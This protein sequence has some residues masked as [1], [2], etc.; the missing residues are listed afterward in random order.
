MDKVGNPS[1]SVCGDPVSWELS[2][3]LE[4][5]KIEPERVRL[6]NLH[7]WSRCQRTADEDER[8]IAGAMVMIALKLLVL[9]SC[10]YM[11][12]IHSPIHALAV[13]TSLNRESIYIGLYDCT[14]RVRISWE[15]LAGTASHFICCIQAIFFIHSKL[16]KIKSRTFVRISATLRFFCSWKLGGN[17][18]HFAIQRHILIQ[19]RLD[20]IASCDALQFRKV[21][22]KRK[23]IWE[24]SKND[25]IQ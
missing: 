3:A 23:K 5:V 1:N 9:P 13:V 14:V 7:C 2:S 10:V 16:Q 8:G 11:W 15:H 18:S 20:S 19:N 21:R 12:S 6:R 25:Y 17:S 22:K 24:P 4:S